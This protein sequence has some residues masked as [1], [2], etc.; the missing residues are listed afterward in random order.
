M[1]GVLLHPVYVTDDVGSPVVDVAVLVLD[2]I[3]VGAGLLVNGE[4]QGQGV[5]DLIEDVGSAT[6][7]VD[8]V[9]VEH[10]VVDERFH[11]AEARASDAYVLLPH[12]V[13]ALAHVLVADPSLVEAPCGLETYTLLTEVE[14]D[15][16]ILRH[17]R[18]G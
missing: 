11:G 3:L 14:G 6:H 1:P 10:R 4:H 17:Y 15:G 8:G 2:E 18:A 9:V 16:D 7:V 13:D 5:A 12:V